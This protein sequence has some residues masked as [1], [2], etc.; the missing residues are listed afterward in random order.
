MKNPGITAVLV[1]LAFLPTD[2][3]ADAPPKPE[4]GVLA[5]GLF[6]GGVLGWGLVKANG[7]LRAGV[8]VLGAA[9]GSGPVLFM[10]SVGDARWAYPIGLILG[11][12][13][14]YAFRA[15]SELF[16]VRHSKG[17]RLFA[18]AELCLIMGTTLAAA[19]YSAL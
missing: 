11:L 2:A 15:R 13:A 3:L 12:V 1:W 19:V 18:F 4:M 5:L 7:H 17:E 16:D 10:R 8:A 9:L 6:V 14:L